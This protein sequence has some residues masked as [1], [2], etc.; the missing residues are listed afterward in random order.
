MSASGNGVID[1]FEVSKWFGNVVAV[2]EVSFQVHPGITALLGPNGAGKTTMLHLIAGLAK[3]SDG[4]VTTLGEPVRNNPEIYRR[5][6]FM[7]EHE[8]V[9][10]F[11][12]G[13][14]LV[15]FSAKL[16][17]LN[18]VDEAVDKAIHIVGME[19]AQ[20]R[21]MGGYSRGMRQRM[22][23]AAAIVH[24]PEVM[25]L[26]EPLNGTDPRQRIEF[27]QVM[28]RLVSQG[29]TI[30]I[31]SHILEEVETMAGR[32]LL[33]VSGKLAAS[34]DFRAIRA[35]LDEQAYQV[36]IV[37]DDPRKMAAAIV[38]LEDVDSINFDDD[39]S[40]IVHSRKVAT[41]QT[42]LPRLALENGIRLTRMEAI[43]ESLESMF[44]Y[45]VER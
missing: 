40:I 21:A 23:L 34:G 8:S 13:R 30:L 24:D 4:Q 44:E 26:D 10:G 39:G 6:G 37:V 29:R 15:Q 14:Q 38:A 19:D 3:C 22:R 20:D 9:Y 16:H 2:N 35:K 12:T 32:I 5:V 11:Y 27:Q 43:D 25:I 42:N 7:P 1:V 36:R 45:I 31:S 41:I 33:M 28:E 17:G 18:P